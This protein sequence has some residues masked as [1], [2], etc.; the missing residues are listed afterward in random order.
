MPDF[1]NRTYLL[2]LRE[3]QFLPAEDDNPFRENNSH[4]E[5]ENLWLPL[6][7]EIWL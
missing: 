4:F 2:K 3:L 7:P 6:L 5:K 1:N